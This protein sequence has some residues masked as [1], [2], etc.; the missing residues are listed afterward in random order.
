MMLGSGTLPG[1]GCSWPFCMNACVCEH[2]AAL[3]RRCSVTRTVLGWAS[4]LGLGSKC[5]CLRTAPAGC[6][7]L[8]SECYQ[9]AKRSQQA[10][11]HLL[12]HRATVNYQV[13]PSS[14]GNPRAF[15]MCE[16]QKQYQPDD[17]HPFRRPHSW[18]D[19]GMDNCS[20]KT[21]STIVQR[22]NARLQN[23]YARIPHAAAQCITQCP[24]IVARSGRS[25]A[26]EH[27]V[28]WPL[29]PGTYHGTE[30]FQYKVLMSSPAAASRLLCADL[31]GCECRLTRRP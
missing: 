24:L 13:I 1:H 31:S 9:T 23:W 5:R 20:P 7:Y 11:A 29:E 27:Y 8:L 30:S 15:S 16:T 14:N 12:Q 28:A 25:L 21:I 18:P 10:F 3:V 19:R 2:D 17:L 22:R 4:L 26:T 6:W